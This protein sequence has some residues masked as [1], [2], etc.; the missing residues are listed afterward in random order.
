MK[1]S[2]ANCGEFNHELSSR[3][4]EANVLKKERRALT[5]RLKSNDQ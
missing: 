5:T 4:G 1:T 3:Q 2:V